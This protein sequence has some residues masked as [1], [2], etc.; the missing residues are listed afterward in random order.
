M[1]A[2][3]FTVDGCVNSKKIQKI[4]S[5]TRVICLTH[6]RDLLVALPQ[7]HGLDSKLISGPQGSMD[8]LVI[9][10]ELFCLVSHQ[11]KV[12]ND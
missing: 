9:M 2:V 8:C 7:P 5:S 6:Y 11:A 4:H 12:K 3:T 1:V 10:Y